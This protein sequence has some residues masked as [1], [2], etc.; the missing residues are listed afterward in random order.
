MDVK[1]TICIKKKINLYLKKNITIAIKFRK[2]IGKK[3]VWSIIKNKKTS[4]L[5]LIKNKK[6]E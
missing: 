1:T 6:D 4:R 3:K 5:N 2:K